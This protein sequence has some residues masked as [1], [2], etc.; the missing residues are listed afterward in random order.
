M[1]NLD[2]MM[3]SA[4]EDEVNEYLTNCETE[5]GFSVGDVQYIIKR[6]FDTLNQKDEGE[7][8]EYQYYISHWMSKEGSTV[9]KYMT[10]EEFNKM[11]RSKSHVYE[12]I[13]SS[14]RPRT[15]E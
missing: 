4:L 9:S 12:K 15:S 3:I 13:V 11:P 8:M 5:Y 1:N 14:G 6:I 2:R 7:V 10:D